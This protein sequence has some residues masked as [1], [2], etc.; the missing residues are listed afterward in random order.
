[1]NN[2]KN[3]NRRSRFKPNGERGFRRNGNGHK[4]NGD[5]GNVLAPV[6][7]MVGKSMW[8]WWSINGTVIDSMS[9]FLME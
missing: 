3:N 2:F 4:P 1:M 8:L 9:I 7:S 5:F 6:R